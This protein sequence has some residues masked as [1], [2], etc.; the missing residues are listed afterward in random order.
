MLSNISVFS[1]LRISKVIPLVKK[2]D[3]AL[4][5]NYR[6]ISVFPCFI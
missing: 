6:P 4:I 5:D 2:G 1:A 3:N